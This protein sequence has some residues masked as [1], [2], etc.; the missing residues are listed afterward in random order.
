MVNSDGGNGGENG[1]LE[2]FWLKKKLKKVR[3]SLK[4][5]PTFSTRVV[6]KPMEASRPP[7]CT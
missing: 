2:T 4:A 7:L 3:E 5:G 1:V 6:S